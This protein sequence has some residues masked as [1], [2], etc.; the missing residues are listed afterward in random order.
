MNSET[1]PVGSTD[2]FHFFGTSNAGLNVTANEL[3][4]MRD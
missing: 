1:L 2:T 3:G 4:R